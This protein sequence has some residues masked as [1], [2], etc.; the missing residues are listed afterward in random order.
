M[1]IEGE[2]ADGRRFAFLKPSGECARPI[3][4][5]ILLETDGCVVTPTLGS[6]VAN[7][8]LI[9]P[10][11][12][13]LNFAQW[14]RTTGR[15][16]L[17]LVKSVM[18]SC[19]FP[20]DRLV[21]FEHGPAQTGSTIG[22]GVDQAHVHVIY[23]APFSAEQVQLIAKEHSQLDWSIGDAES[24]YSSIRLQNSYLVTGSLETAALAQDVEQVGSQ[25]FRRMIAT[26]SDRADAWN[27]RTHPHLSNV[28]ETIRSF[29]TNLS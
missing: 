12:P 4:D 8:L 26:L 14:S 22:C 15:S 17:Q 16:P 29:R 18:A 2:M 3:Y 9:V 28:R 20:T 21:W 19:A 11:S 1:S 25:F 24:V 6:I 27:Y 7:W 10:R 23:D 13:V 5:Q